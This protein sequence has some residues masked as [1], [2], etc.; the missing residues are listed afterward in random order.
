VHIIS[1]EKL[2]N[3]CGDLHARYKPLTVFR[4]RFHSSYWSH[5]AK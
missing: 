1:S 5:C 3:V 2:L 4:R